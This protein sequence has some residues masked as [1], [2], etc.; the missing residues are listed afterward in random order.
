MGNPILAYTIIYALGI[1]FVYIHKILYPPMR[2]A[3]SDYLHNETFAVC[4]SQT[5]MTQSC[6]YS[7][8]IWKW[9]LSG[10]IHA[11]RIWDHEQL[12]VLTEISERTAK[13]DQNRNKIDAV[14]LIKTL[15]HWGCRQ[16]DTE[17]AHSSERSPG[18][19]QIAAR[20]SRNDLSPR[21]SQLAFLF[22]KQPRPKAKPVSLL[23][24]SSQFRSQLWTKS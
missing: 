6:I 8:T 19:R 2:S 16:W 23:L 20:E 10:H 17:K 21:V 4:C 3:M 1:V 13:T 5:V 12:A 18:D 14:A 15:A 24:T 7:T 11:C 9:L 22:K